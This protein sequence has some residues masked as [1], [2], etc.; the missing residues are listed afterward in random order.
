M[1]SEVLRTIDVRPSRPVSIGDPIFA[2]K[3]KT[4]PIRVTVGLAD[5]VDPSR[6]KVEIWSA[7]GPGDP[8][9]RR[10][11]TVPAQL[12]RNLV[13]FMLPMGAPLPPAHLT[14]VSRE[15]KLSAT[16]PVL[17]HRELERHL[18]AHLIRAHSG[19]VAGTRGRPGLLRD[20]SQRTLM[21]TVEEHS[22]LIND[23]IR[24]PVN[25][26]RLPTSSLVTTHNVMRALAIQG[27]A[28][29]STS[30]GTK[31]HVW[32]SRVLGQEVLTLPRLKVRY[33]ETR[34][35][36]RDAGQLVRVWR[37]AVPENRAPGSLPL[38]TSFRLSVAAQQ[39]EQAAR[40][41]SVDML[42]ALDALLATLGSQR[43]I[44]D[45]LGFR[46]TFSTSVFNEKT[47]CTWMD[48]VLAV[49]RVYRRVCAS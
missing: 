17:S 10:L 6:Q 25:V 35:T 40:L 8:E 24:L 38:D 29:P 42:A 5:G 19:F 23:V 30:E 16:L 31:V 13:T 15:G 49:S 33:R 26:V 18:A 36:P 12:D 47:L 4:E 39:P 20:N 1:V 3:V 45:A 37:N 2:G 9:A 14:A 32:E 28:A 34:S 27:T 48:R 21:I 22:S 43:V 11:A 7:H 44:F 46:T 41:L